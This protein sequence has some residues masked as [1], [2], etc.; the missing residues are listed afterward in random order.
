MKPL[1]MCLCSCLLA[2]APV[3]AA[4]Q[5]KV[6][7]YELKQVWASEPG[8]D[9]AFALE[10]RYFIP[11][12]LPGAS[13]DDTGAVYLCDKLSE[14][15]VKLGPGGHQVFAVGQVGEGPE[16]HSGAGEPVLWGSG[17]M[18]RADCSTSPK[19]IVY[20]TGGEYLES[21]NLDF[22][23]ELARL[24]WNGSHGLAVAFRNKFAPPDAFEFS[25]HLLLLDGRGSVL[26]DRTLRSKRVVRAKSMPE[27]SM[28]DVPRMAVSD[29]GFCFI[30]NDLY[31]NVIECLD[32]DLKPLWTITGPWQP[33]TRTPEELAEAQAIGVTGLEYSAVNQTI[34][35][36]VARTGGEVWVQPWRPGVVDGVVEFASFGRDGQVLGA[37]RIAGLPKLSG[38]WILRGNKVLWITSD[39][40]PT[41]IVYDLVATSR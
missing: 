35:R 2:I 7:H 8:D 40:V 1:C 25:T 3:R 19:V 33:S 18:A 36:M 16:D 12:E 39:E 30:Q 24:F 10:P 14:A 4:A 37:V 6:T 9:A 41:I 23:G 20:S 17:K 22:G 21:Y 5:D 27:S 28:W 13:V 31:G 29:D 26:Q 32:R 11:D 38:D 34:R 15:L